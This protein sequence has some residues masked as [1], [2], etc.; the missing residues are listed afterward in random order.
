MSTLVFDCTLR[1]EVAT[2]ALDEFHLVGKISVERAG[3]SSQAYQLWTMYFDVP[4]WL[5]MNGKPI[6]TLVGGRRLTC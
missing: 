2:A 3:G 5:A 4:P 6:E 1:A